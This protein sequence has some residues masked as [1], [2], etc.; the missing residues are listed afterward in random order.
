MNNLWYWCIYHV[1]AFD[2]IDLKMF[3]DFGKEFDN[4]TIIEKPLTVTGLFWC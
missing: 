4:V 3:M 2:S 1:K